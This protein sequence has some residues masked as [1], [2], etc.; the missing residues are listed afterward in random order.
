MELKHGLR[1][2]VNRTPVANS[3]FDNLFD[4][5]ASLANFCLDEESWHVLFNEI[6]AIFAAFFNEIAAN[7]YM[8]S[9]QASDYLLQAV[10]RDKFGNQ[11]APQSRQ[12]TRND[13]LEAEAWAKKF[14]NPPM[15]RAVTSSKGYTHRTMV[16]VRRRML[17]FSR[18]TFNFDHFLG[19][20]WC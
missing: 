15:T 17:T 6:A 19:K 8:H 13:L 5:T 2:P 1:E 3:V 14:L 11:E 18:L 4:D 12:T 16:K 20:L 10:E 7:F 9:L